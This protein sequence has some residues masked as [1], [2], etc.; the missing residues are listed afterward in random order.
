MKIRINKDL[1]VAALFVITVHVCLLFF[2]PPG[3]IIKPRLGGERKAM[4]VSL[5]K[6]QRAKPSVPKP[7]VK[8]KKVLKKKR[9]KPKK[10]PVPKLITKKKVEKLIKEEERKKE[11]DFISEENKTELLE[12]HLESAAAI[13]PEGSEEESETVEAVVTK[14]VPRYLENPKPTYPRVARRRGQQ[15]T[16]I[17]KV[18]V[19]VDGSAGRVKLEKSSGFAALDDAAKETVNNWRFFP[20]KIGNIPTVMWVSIPIRFELG[21]Q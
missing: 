16:V 12:E 1:L 9:V 18:E 5:V 11:P 13:K 4:E 21:Y 6:S 2:N 19:L 8:P 15:G 7:L 14:A 10:S 3:L 17:L 20:G